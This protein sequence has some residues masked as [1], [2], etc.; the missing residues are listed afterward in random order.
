MY[1]LLGEKKYRETNREIER[2]V[3]EANIPCERIAIGVTI[4]GLVTKQELINAGADFVLGR[5]NNKNLALIK[6]IIER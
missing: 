6:N 3:K 4:C 5:Y 2:M 1:Y